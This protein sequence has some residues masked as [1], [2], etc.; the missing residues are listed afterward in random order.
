M[1]TIESL[2]CHLQVVVFIVGSQQLQK[3]VVSLPACT[4]MQI[5]ACSLL[6]KGQVQPIH[7]ALR[8]ID[9]NGQLLIFSLGFGF[10]LGS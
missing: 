3:A 5:L 4:H 6:T 10:S 1:C 9:H 8:C 7:S 2:S